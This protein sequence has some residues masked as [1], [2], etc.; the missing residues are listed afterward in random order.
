MDQD[1]WAAGDS[2][3]FPGDSDVRQGWILL[4]LNRKAGTFQM[5]SQRWPSALSTPGCPLRLSITDRGAWAKNN[6]AESKLARVQVL[7][8]SHSGQNCKPGQSSRADIIGF[9][10]NSEYE[11]INKINSKFSGKELLNPEKFQIIVFCNVFC[12]LSFVVVDFPLQK[13]SSPTK[14]M[15]KYIQG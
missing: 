14:E 11:K 8:L 13:Q 7:N 15:G 12:W 4:W 2:E 3:N 9:K 6:L 5:A 10:M 1:L